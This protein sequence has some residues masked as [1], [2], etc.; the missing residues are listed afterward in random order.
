VKHDSVNATV[1]SWLIDTYWYVPAP[2]LPALLAMNASEPRII[3]VQ[4]Q[5]VWHITNSSNG[6]LSGISASNIGLGWNY[7]LIVGSVTP[8]RTVKLSFSP[9]SDANSADP[10]TQSITIGDGTLLGEG[11]DAEFVMQMTSG[12]PTTS[13]THWARML[14]ITSA[15]A[16][17][18]SLPGYPT[19][20][21]PDLTGL[22]ASIAYK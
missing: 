2:Y 4:D 18:S 9:R 17:W 7:M 8:S 14:P 12:T 15:D 3:T 6:Y 5:T 22:Q 16:E 21:V 13:L 1:A 10:S 11:P 19:T 20:G